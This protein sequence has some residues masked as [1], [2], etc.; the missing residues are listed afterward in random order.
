MELHFLQP[1]VRKTGDSGRPSETTPEPSSSMSPAPQHSTG[2][3]GHFPHG[4]QDLF[5][6]SASQEKVDFSCLISM[7]I[8]SSPTSSAAVSRN[9]KTQ[10]KT[11]LFLHFPPRRWYLHGARLPCHIRSLHRTASAP[12][13]QEK[14]QGTPC[15]QVFFCL[16]GIKT[17]QLFSKGHSKKTK[18]HQPWTLFQLLSRQLSPKH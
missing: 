8:I 18:H 17:H 10:P 5:F 4:L 6:I 1:T 11:W 9:S 7:D 15:H 13:Q 16:T 14:V 12:R 3:R 2:G